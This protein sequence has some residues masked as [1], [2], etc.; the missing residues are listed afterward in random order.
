M[1]RTVYSNKILAI[2]K[3]IVMKKK[4]REFLKLAGM[5][6]IGL[7]S[8]PG[9][10]RAFD[11]GQD[12]QRRHNN[13]IVDHAV[14]TLEDGSK[15]AT[16]F[17][18]IDSG[19]DGPSLLLIAAQ[20]GNEIQGAEVAR[21]FKEVCAGQLL[22]GTVWLLPM[23]NLQAIR[24]RRHSLDLGP[25]Q[26]GSF[27]KGHNM[28]QTWPGDPKGNNTE[29][30]TY[31]LDQTILRHCS[32]LVDMHCWNHFWAAETLDVTEH[33][34]SNLLGE[35]TTTRFA[36]YLDLRPSTE[37]IRSISQLIRRRGGGATIIELSGQYQMQEQQV[38]LGLMSMVNIA[39]RLGMFEGEPEL[40]TGPKVLRNSENSNDVHVTNSGIFMPALRKDKSGSLAPEDYVE[41]GH[42]LGHIIRENDLEAEP[43]IAPVSGY[44]WHLGTCHSGCDAS[45]PAQHP[46]TMEGDK[47]AT[48]V[49]VSGNIN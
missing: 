41:K 1:I 33:K 19:K 34:P 11:F 26:P 38:Q 35:V 39:K 37:P 48:I 27:S 22:A 18:R 25:E 42:L 32:H 10:V 40:T 3:N 20:H 44:L 8:S 9:I 15:L 29:R 23:A 4:R 43:I 5:A 2:I 45:L 6:G 31:A 12:H 7:A 36:S 21:R 17:W 46:Y 13:V 28:Q 14:A 24:L 16:P 49:T 47:I 30:M